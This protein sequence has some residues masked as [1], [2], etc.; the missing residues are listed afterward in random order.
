M[1]VLRII[2]PYG[3]RYNILE[4]GNI[5]RLDIK[6]FEPSGEWKLL[7]LRHVNRNEFIPLAKITPELLKSLPILYKNGNPQ[8]TIID[9]DHGSK[10]MWGNTKV[11]G[12][13]EIYF[14]E[15]QS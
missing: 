7:G 5:V 13:K 10:R 14:E 12:I 11:N 4:N 8:W 2:T 9:Y 3:D 1:R 6:D 15:V